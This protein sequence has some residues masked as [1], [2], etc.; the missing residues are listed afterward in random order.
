VSVSFGSLAAE[1]L[2]SRGSFL[3]QTL[4]WLCQEAISGQERPLSVEVNI[5]TQIKIL[6]MWLLAYESMAMITI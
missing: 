2:I 3:V 4:K 5:Y 6:T 1:F